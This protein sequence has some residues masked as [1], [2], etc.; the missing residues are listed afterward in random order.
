MALGY[1]QAEQRQR[2]RDLG[3]VVE[4]REYDGAWTS[5]FEEHWLK[6]R[7][8]AMGYQHVRFFGGTTCEYDGSF[9]ERI[10]E[11]KRAGCAVEYCVYG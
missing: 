4:Y 9:R 3:E 2:Y 8:L 6:P 7:L 1:R 5:W 10:C 11:L